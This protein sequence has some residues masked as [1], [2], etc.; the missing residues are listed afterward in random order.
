M[1]TRS[2]S[3]II[4]SAYGRRYNLES[5]VVMERPAYHRPLSARLSAA[6]DMVQMRRFQITSLLLVLLV[7]VATVYYYNVLVKTRSDVMA[8]RGRVNALLQRRHDISINLSKA[9]SDYSVHERNVFTAVVALRSMLAKNTSGDENLEG[10]LGRPA[11]PETV[12]LPAAESPEA[13]A[14]GAPAGVA[15]GAPVEMAKGTVAEVATGAA[16][17]DGGAGFIVHD[18]PDSGRGGTVSGPETVRNLSELYGGPHRGGEGP[19]HGENEAKRFGQYIHH[20]CG[21]VSQQSLC[22]SFW[23][24]IGALL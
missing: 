15:E 9:V 12:A 18:G 19:G 22:I 5:G 3:R 16:G 20:H 13:V 24:R 23:I 17:R 21:Q 4:Q 1:K 8:G 2:I 14:A 10:L 7:V 11:L 6:M